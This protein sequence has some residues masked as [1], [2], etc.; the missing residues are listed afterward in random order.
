MHFSEDRIYNICHK[1]HDR[2]YL[3]ELVDYTDEEE[4]LRIIKKTVFDFLALNDQLDDQVRDKIRS[5]K[6]GVVE[7]T[8]EWEVLYKK[9]YEEELVKKKL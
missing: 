3:D 5:L 6:K 2:L 7:G 1:I 9:Y 4:A 8:P